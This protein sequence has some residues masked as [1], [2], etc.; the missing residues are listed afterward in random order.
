MAL[1]DIELTVGKLETRWMAGLPF[2]VGPT[3]PRIGGGRSSVSLRLGCFT[4]FLLTRVWMNET[5]HKQDGVDL[6][7]QLVE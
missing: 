1:Q 7:W 6:P 3:R 4:I 5:S 2:L